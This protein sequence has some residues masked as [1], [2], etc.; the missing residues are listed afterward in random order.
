MAELPRMQA[1]TGSSRKREIRVASLF[2]EV[3]PEF[4]KMIVVHELAHLKERQHDRA[5]YQLCKPHGTRI[6]PAGFDLRLYLTQAR[7][8]WLAR[9]VTAGRRHQIPYR[10]SSPLSPCM[11]KG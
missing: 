3:P 9:R 2:R 10:R 8:E 7:V 5:F 11:T 4:L 1:A 6:P